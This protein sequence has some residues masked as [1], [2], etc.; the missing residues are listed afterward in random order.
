[1]TVIGY[2]HLGFLYWGTKTCSYSW[3][4]GLK[5]KTTGQRTCWVLFISGNLYDWLHFR[6]LVEIRIPTH[7][8]THKGTHTQN[9]MYSLDIFV[10][11]SLPRVLGL[12]AQNWAQAYPPR[13]AFWDSLSCCLGWVYPFPTASTLAYVTLYFHILFF[14]GMLIRHN[15]YGEHHFIFRF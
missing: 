2:G 4:L 6:R 11:F 15:H 7:L 3:G 5:C 14:S 13:E 8:C 12:I 9:S 10:L 1:M